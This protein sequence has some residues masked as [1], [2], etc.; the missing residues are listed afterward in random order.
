MKRA[1]S[2]L[3]DFITEEN[4]SSASEYGSTYLLVAIALAIVFVVF[5]GSLL[6]TVHT[7]ADEFVNKMDSLSVANQGQPRNL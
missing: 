6:T 5:Q 4:G 2:F 3:K 7:I 1:I